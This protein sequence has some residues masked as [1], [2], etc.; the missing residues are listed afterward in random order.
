[1]EN[2]SASAARKATVLNQGLWHPNPRFIFRN[3][4]VEF[5]SKASIPF[6]SVLLSH[7]PVVQMELM[8]IVGFIMLLVDSLYEPRT[9][10][11]CSVLVFGLR[12][13]TFLMMLIGLSVAILNDPN[14]SEPLWALVCVSVLVP[15]WMI[16]RI[17]KHA[18]S[19][20]THV[21]WKS[22][23]APGTLRG[24]SESVPLLPTTP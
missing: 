20:K 11:V 12:L 3:N 9:E 23:A 4:M 5:L 17:I 24:E 15:A 8:S 7:R 10:P 18:K 21:T 19:L 16:W 14:R 13:L 2:W 22:I 6:I 1:M